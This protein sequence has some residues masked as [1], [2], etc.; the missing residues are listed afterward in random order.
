MT[1]PSP[2]RR[3]AGRLLIAAGVLALPLTASISYAAA[4]DPVPPPTPAAP[5][6]GHTRMEKRIV[7]VEKAGPTKDDSKL[8]TRVITRDGK[9]IVF[10]TDKVLSD[11][12]IDKRVE[13]AMAKM[14]AMPDMPGM[15]EPEV[16][17][18]MIVKRMD[19]AG[20]PGDVAVD[21][22]TFEGTDCKGGEPTEVDESADA[23]GQHHR[24]RIKICAKQYAADAIRKARDEVAQ[25]KSIPE[26]VRTKVLKEL[27]EE[28]ARNAKQ[29]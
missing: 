3:L 24:I 26:D 19:L 1:E 22:E 27:D 15:A 23:D 7:I 8:K 29:G 21:A 5:A 18:R 16:R 13:E 17:H 14:P 10:K 9:T 2:R 28:L 25:D 20:A 12:E 6:G 4:D 11:A